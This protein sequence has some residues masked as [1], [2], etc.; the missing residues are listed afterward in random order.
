MAYDWSTLCMFWWPRFHRF[1]TNYF[2]LSLKC[3]LS[4]AY[5]ARGLAPHLGVKDDFI[6]SVAASMTL[7]RGASLQDVCAAESWSFPH[8]FIRFYVVDVWSTLGSQVLL[9]CPIPKLQLVLV[10]LSHLWCRHP[11][12][13]VAWS[14]TFPLC[15]QHD[16]SS[17]FPRKGTSQGYVHNPVT[18]DGNK[19]MRRVAILQLRLCGF[20]R[21][22]NL[23]DNHAGALYKCSHVLCGVTWHHPWPI[24][25][26]HV[27]HMVQTPARSEGFPLHQRHD[28]YVTLRHF[29]LLLIWIE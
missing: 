1:Q 24:G 3:G 2:S 27:A 12:S 4:V 22:S 21:Q 14:L 28:T 26:W 29:P 7:A 8:T 9:G 17:M 10:Q 15:P 25:A 16:A 11:L 13:M 18:W 23:N 5:E 20:F 19:T 6:R